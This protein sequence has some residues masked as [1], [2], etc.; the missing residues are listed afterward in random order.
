MAKILERNRK[1]AMDSQSFDI[2]DIVIVFKSFLLKME[3]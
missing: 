3:T 1:K 2:W